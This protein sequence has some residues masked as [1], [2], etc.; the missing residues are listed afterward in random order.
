LDAL[1][2]GPGTTLLIDGATGGAGAGRLTMHVAT[3]Y[4]MSAGAAAHARVAT[5]H[6]RGKVVI[7]VAE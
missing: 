7:E 3:T 1:H 4:S 6:T 5:G 2:V